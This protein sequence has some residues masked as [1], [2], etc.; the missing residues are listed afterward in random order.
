MDAN[1]EFYAPSAEQL[2]RVEVINALRSLGISPEAMPALPI[3]QIKV[4]FTVEIP[5]VQ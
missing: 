1:F 5:D 3:K 2:I 4:I